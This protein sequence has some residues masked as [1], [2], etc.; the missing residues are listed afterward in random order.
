MKTT[1]VLHAWACILAGRAPSL[2]IEIV[3][4]RLASLAGLNV[5]RVR[6]K[7]AL[8]KDVQLVE[9]FDREQQKGGWSRKA[10]GIGNAKGPAD[11]PAKLIA[12][13]VRKADERTDEGIEA[14][15]AAVQSEGHEENEPAQACSRATEPA[16]D[17]GPGPA[18]IR[19]CAGVRSSKC[20]IFSFRLKSRH[21][22]NKDLFI[23]RVLLGVCGR[24][25]LWQQIE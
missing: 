16:C 24:R 25:R 8:G 11:T 7:A 10:F 22:N 6:M 17:P 15:E 23:D 14:R 4:M 12:A 21:T 20:N 9:R 18:E 3:A 5:S 2:S 1:E 13:F 19:V